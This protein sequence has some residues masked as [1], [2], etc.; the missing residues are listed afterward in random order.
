MIERTE[1]RPS[2]KKVSIYAAIIASAVR[3]VLYRPRNPWDKENTSDVGAPISRPVGARI[4]SNGR[5][6]KAQLEQ[7]KIER[8]R[9]HSAPL[10]KCHWRV[11]WSIA[12]TTFQVCGRWHLTRDLS[13]SN[14]TLFLNAVWNLS[15]AEIRQHRSFSFHRRNNRPEIVWQRARARARESGDYCSRQTIAYDMRPT[16]A[17]RR[18]GWW[19]EH[20]RSVCAR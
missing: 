1:C 16:N 19:R 10:R 20:K 15:L 14:S 18:V 13:P 3:S 8:K 5:G 4:K 6:D 11:L 9:E 2:E 7:S 17:I 12:G